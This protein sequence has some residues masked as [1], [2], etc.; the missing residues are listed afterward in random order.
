MKRTS[1]NKIGKIGQANIKSRKIIAEICEQKGLNYCE[2]RLEGCMGTFGIAPAHRHRRG[3]YQGNP[4]RLADF[5]EWVVA[6]QY[7]HQKIDSNQELLE[8]TFER[9]R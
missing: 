2:V 7:C 5:N 3:Y 9:L 8:Q 6:C 1:L 4:E